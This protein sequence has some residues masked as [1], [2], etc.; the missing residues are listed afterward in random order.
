MMSSLLSAVVALRASSGKKRGWPNTERSLWNDFGHQS[1][2]RLVI[3]CCL[4]WRF[5]LGSIPF[6]EKTSQ[7]NHHELHAAL[8]VFLNLQTIQ[9]ESMHTPAGVFEGDIKSTE[10]Q[11]TNN[12]LLAGNPGEGSSQSNGLMES[13]LTSL[14]VVQVSTRSFFQT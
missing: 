4:K 6:E 8:N 1:W 9:T 5:L 7:I 11:R 13:S 3:F 12:M 10:E 2:E 14:T